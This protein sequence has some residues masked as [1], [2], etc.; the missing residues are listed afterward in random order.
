[1]YGAK[2]HQHQ[3]LY[4]TGRGKKTP[5]GGQGERRGGSIFQYFPVCSTGPRRYPTSSQRTQRRQMTPM[6]G[7]WRRVG[8]GV[9]KGS[10]GADGT[11]D[12]LYIPNISTDSGNIFADLMARVCCKHQIDTKHTRPRNELS[13]ISVPT[14]SLRKLPCLPRTLKGLVCIYIYLYTHAHRVR[15]LPCGR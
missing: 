11:Q 7:T 5:A 13:F 10:C 8:E 1:M 15:S 9:M 14:W 2:P 3:S 4:H 12:V 6:S